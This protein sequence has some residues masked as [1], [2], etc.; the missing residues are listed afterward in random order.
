MHTTQRPTLQMSRL[1][2][3]IGGILLLA[4]VTIEFGGLYLT[5]VASGQ[6]ELTDFQVA[7]SR[8]GHAHAGVLVTLS[9]ITLV[10]ADA[11]DLRGGLGYV[12]RLAIPLAA[13]LMSAGFF[14]SSMG[15]G[16]TG[17]SGLIVMLW[18]GGAS[19]AVGVVV[20]GIALLR[21]AFGP[22]TGA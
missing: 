12:A 1:S 4:V 6:V 17:P 19:L 15:A 8:A 7:F 3:R 5:R 18:L 11:T 16:R 20:L 10:L 2:R 14:L 22:E 21:G 9:L 13:I